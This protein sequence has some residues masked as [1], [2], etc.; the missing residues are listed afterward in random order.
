LLARALARKPELL[1]LD[2]PTVA[3]DPGSRD[4]FY[5]IMQKLNKEKGMTILLVSHDIGSIG[6]YTSKLMYLDGKIIF[7]GN[8]DEFCVSTNMTDYFGKTSQH[9]ICHR[10]G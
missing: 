8:Y 10:H 4:N 7:Y 2:E 5:S 9:L 1:I 6:E 3:L